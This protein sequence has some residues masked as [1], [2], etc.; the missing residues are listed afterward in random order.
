MSQDQQSGSSATNIPPEYQGV[1]QEQRFSS[2][3]DKLNRCYSA[4][5]YEDFEGAVEKIL[6]KHIEMDST[7]DKL[8]AWV[9]SE[10]RSVLSDSRWKNL[11]FWLPF[12][13]SVAA[14]V[15]AFVKG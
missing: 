8:K 7:K 3:E 15:V 2:I 5:R 10:V 14:V 12:A 9:S 4:D 13:V 6:L 11:S 1:F